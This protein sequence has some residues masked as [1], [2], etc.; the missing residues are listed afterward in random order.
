MPASKRKIVLV[1]GGSVAWG[2]GLLRDMLLSQPL[3]G[4]QY[5]LYD[6]DKPSADLIAAVGENL[7]RTV[8]VE[9]RFVPTDNRARALKG[10]DY[11]IITIS[12]GGLDATAMDLSIPERFGIY[13]TVGDTSGPG[14]WARFIRNF[15]AF[16]ALARDFNRCAPDALILNYSNPMTALTDVL[17][18]LCGGR[19]IGVCH[20]LRSNQYFVRDFYRLKD[21][22]QTAFKIGGVNHFFW[23]TH[24]RAGRIDVIADLRRRL[25][26][27]TLRDLL[28]QAYPDGHPA[29][30]PSL[31]LA[32][33]LFRLTGVMP[34]LADRHICE[35][36]NWCVTSKEGL[37]RYKVPRTTAAEQQRNLARRRRRAERMVSH[38][39]PEFLKGDPEIACQIIAAHIVGRPTAVD[40]GNLPN[41]SQVQNLPAG[42][43][44]ETGVCVDSNGF[45]PLNFGPLP[46]AVLGLVEP[47]TRVFTMAVDACFRK[48]RKMALQAL[49]LDPLCAHL[50]TD[51]VNELAQRLLDAHRRFI[52]V[53]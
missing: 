48:D 1:G 11:V 51:V 23:A 16:V 38:I 17:S 15:D 34:F 44:V 22:G 19:V 3:K 14:G 45:T 37:R 7:A 42:A 29:I 28:K 33:E 25:R 8:G 10:A 40:M 27:Q 30:N 39:D 53:F 46:P 31:T 35:F 26:K 43:V 49:R 6:I 21:L 36:V 12:T 5:F 41:T 24:A 20:G 13:H 47:W 2:P 4:S 52:T 32:T 9:A 18:R 50:N